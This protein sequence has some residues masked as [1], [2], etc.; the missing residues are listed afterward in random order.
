MGDYGEET[1]EMESW[2]VEWLGVGVWVK[3]WFRES[4]PCSRE[5]F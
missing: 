2:G 4:V 3:E 5:G 1:G